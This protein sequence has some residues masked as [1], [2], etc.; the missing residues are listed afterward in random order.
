MER[1][2]WESIALLIDNGWK[3]EFDDTMSSSY[4]TLLGRFTR[5]QV[6]GALYGI[7][8][9]GKP[10]VP[11]VPEIVSEVRKQEQPSLPSWTEVWSKIEL[12]MSK[13]KTEDEAVAELTEYCHPVAGAFMR[14]EGFERLRREPFLDPDYGTLRVRELQRRWVEFSEVNQEKIRNGKAIEAYSRTT[15]GLQRASAAGL[16]SQ[17]SEYP[18]DN[19][20][21]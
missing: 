11:S 15:K 8:E 21:I 20:T 14:L 10:F 13:C 17:M 16:I 5:E 2:E 4:F 19:E 7:I 3:G 1:D 12:V 6:M 9:N 18:A